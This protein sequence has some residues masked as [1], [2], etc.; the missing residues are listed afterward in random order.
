MAL[1][2]LVVL[3]MSNVLFVAFFFFSHDGE[4][5]HVVCY[6]GLQALPQWDSS[7]TGIPHLP[8]VLEMS[9]FGLLLSL[10]DLW[11]SLIPNKFWR[12]FWLKAFSP[13]MGSAS[14]GLH[15]AH[16]TCVELWFLLGSTFSTSKLGTHSQSQSFPGSIHG[17]NSP[18]HNFCRD[19]GPCHA[20]VKMLAP[21][22]VWTSA[23]IWM[24]LCPPVQ[25]LES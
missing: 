5:F 9:L 4:F 11:V 10:L 16:V 13:Y 21:I 25:M 3:W 12:F 6:F 24:F 8:R 23:M 14:W 17:G 20:G 2:F 1:Y 7:S 19:K 22:W 15:F 18:L